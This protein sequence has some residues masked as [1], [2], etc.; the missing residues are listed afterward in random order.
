MNNL[1]TLILKLFFSD[2]LYYVCT[3]TYFVVL[4]GSPFLQQSFVVA[5][6]SFIDVAYNI[7]AISWIMPAALYFRGVNDQNFR[8]S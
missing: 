2:Y 8:N 5:C 3:R 6:K 1:Y 7:N 4:L